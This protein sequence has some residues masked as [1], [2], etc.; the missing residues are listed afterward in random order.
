MSEKSTEQRFITPFLEFFRPFPPINV[1]VP[2][3]SRP[4]S[5]SWSSFSASNAA[6]VHIADSWLFR[7]QAVAIISQRNTEITWINE[8]NWW[9]A[10]KNSYY[11][12]FCDERNRWRL[13]NGNL[14][15][16]WWPRL[17]TTGDSHV[18]GHE[19]DRKETVWRQKRSQLIHRQSIVCLC[20]LSPDAI[21]VHWK[22]ATWSNLVHFLFSCR[23]TYHIKSLEKK[24][25]T[26]HNYGVHN[27]I[28]TCRLI[29]KNTHVQRKKEQKTVQRKIEKK[30]RRRQ[31]LPALLARFGLKL[32]LKT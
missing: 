3:I 22:I 25:H 1:C 21:T 20:N 8:E 23:M 7:S 6:S 26:E 9:N 27:T 5:R 2:I 15:A 17:V 14:T 32:C 16:C 19:V 4:T 12:I 18:T 13:A 28:R 31:N 24:T 29:C 11:N 10:T 30:T